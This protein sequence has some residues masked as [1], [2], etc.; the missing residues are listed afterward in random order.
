MQDH[1]AH[2]QVHIQALSERDLD[3]RIEFF[4]EAVHRRAGRVVDIEW[5]DVGGRLA[6]AATVRFALP[7]QHAP[8]AHRAG[9]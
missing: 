3:R 4:M 7:A 2:R 9:G 5:H 1:T 6:H 8:H